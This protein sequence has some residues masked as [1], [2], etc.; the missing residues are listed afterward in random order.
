MARHLLVVVN[1]INIAGA[2]VAES[3]ND[4]PVARHGDGPETGKVSLERM[5]PKARQVHVADL[6]RLV[7]TRQ[8]ALDL[9]DMVRIQPTAVSL[10]EQKPE[11]LMPPADDHSRNCNLTRVR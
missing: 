4:A 11:A 6:G 10:L 2:A 1:Q 5:Q 8:D 7:E 9:S 3:K